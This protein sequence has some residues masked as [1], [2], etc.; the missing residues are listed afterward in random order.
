M[1][2]PF[3]TIFFSTI[4]IFLCLFAHNNMANTLE[5]NPPENFM[6]ALEKCSNNVSYVTTAKTIVDKKEYTMTTKHF[7]KNPKTYRIENNIAGL[8]NILIVTPYKTLNYSDTGK[9]IISNEAKTESNFS[10]FQK[11]QNIIEKKEGDM[12]TYTITD[13]GEK[14]STIFYINSKTGLFEKSVIKDSSDEIITTAAYSNYKFEIL[15]N[16]LFFK[17]QENSKISE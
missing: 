17:N 8:K 13:S 6:K 14:R 7:F 2:N 9:K 12:F 10:N 11:N 1:K 4:I 5:N 16:S 15:N 3:I